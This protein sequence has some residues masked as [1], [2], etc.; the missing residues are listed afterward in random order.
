[1]EVFS[2]IMD[3]GTHL[4][5]RFWKATDE[6]AV[7]QIVHG[8]SEYS[9]RYQDFAQWLTERGVSVYALDNRGHGLNQT[10][11]T[12]KVYM[13]AGDGYKIPKD[14][15]ALGERIARD[16]P[17]V[18]I[19]LL[20]HSMGSFIA[21]AVAGLPNPYDKYIFVGSAYQDPVVL[22]AGRALVRSIRLVKGN[23]SASKV[24][25][26]M[27]FNNL[28]KSMR[29]KGL[30]KDDHEWLTTDIAQGDKNRDDKVLGQKFTLGAYRTLFDLIKQAQ[31]LDTIKN[32]QKPV[33]L[34]T[35]LQDPVSDYGKTVKRLARRY[36]KYGNPHVEEIYYEGMRHEVLN[37]RNRQ[38]V[39]QD[40]LHYIFN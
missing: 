37:E 36:R 17:D 1:M 26:D 20:G 27:T 31:D 15:I 16:H 8:A 23:R 11:G 32:T 5:G 39:Y 30:I 22:K 33:L 13:K 34:L 19:T 14:V 21:R 24:L 29:K 40:T 25:D 28:R 18:E 38:K 4:K 10:P 7:L 12:D 6:K 9:L 3:D 35:G 2:L